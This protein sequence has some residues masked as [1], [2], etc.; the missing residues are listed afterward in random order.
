MPTSLPPGQYQRVLAIDTDTE[1][2]SAVKK[3][4]ETGRCRVECATHAAAALARLEHNGYDLVICDAHMRELE[5]VELYAR[6]AERLA[7]GL[8]LLFLSAAPLSEGE[9]LFFEEHRL[10]CL[11]KPLH[12]RRFLDKLE[13]LLL[14]AA[15][16]PEE[17]QPAP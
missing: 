14:L 7:E 2:L 12:L 15:Q 17:E 11:E 1:F 4:V 8:Q 5:P 16:P 13:D 3:V 9:R 10:T 6:V